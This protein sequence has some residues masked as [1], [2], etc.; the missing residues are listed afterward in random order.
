MGK[1]KRKQQPQIPRKLA[2]AGMNT[3]AQ[4]ALAVERI[5]G[6][7]SQI[8]RPQESI[9]EQ[10]DRLKL[11]YAIIEAGETVKFTSDTLVFKM[12]ELNKAEKRNQDQGSILKRIYDSQ[13]EAVI[14][15][16]EESVP[17]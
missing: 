4:K 11:P 5:K 9:L 7:F 8:A 10:F 13:R 16:G 14:V 17:D 6:L 3:E 12:S 1:K 2:T 15:D